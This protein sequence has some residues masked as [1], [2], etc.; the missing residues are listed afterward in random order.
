MNI[1][2][3]EQLKKSIARVESVESNGEF[4][5]LIFSNMDRYVKV[6]RAIPI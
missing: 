5:S 4:Q 3:Y 6:L 2:K 1:D